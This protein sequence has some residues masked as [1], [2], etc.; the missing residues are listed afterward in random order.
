MESGRR[1]KE[2]EKD[3][4]RQ[5]EVSWMSGAQVRRTSSVCGYSMEQ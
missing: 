5:L 3:D 4:E 2:I 1:V